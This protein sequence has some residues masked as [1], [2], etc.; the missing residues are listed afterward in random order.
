MSENSDKACTAIIL[1]AGRGTRMQSALPKVLHPVCGR[2]M[3]HWIIEATRPLCTRIVVVLGHAREQIQAT[4]P[5]DIQIAIQD[6]PQGTGDAVRVASSK[7]D[8][9]GIVLV[10]PG[11]APLIRQTTLAALIRGHKKALCSVLTAQIAPDQAPTSGYG[12]IVRD[13]TGMPVAIVEKASATAEQLEITEVNTGI[14]AFDAK[15]LFETVLPQLKA[16]PPKNEYYLTDAIQQAAEAG[17]LQAIEHT[18]LTEVTGVNDRIA[19][20]EL[21]SAARAEINREWMA[22][23]VHFVDPA[24]TYIGADVQL[25]PDVSL[26]PGVVLKGHTHIGKGAQIGAYA[27]IEDCTIAENVLVHSHSV[28]QGATLETGA[29]AGP[30]ARLREGTYL[31]P[32][33]KVGNFVEIKKTHL[34]EGAKAGHL[35]YLGDAKIGA[36]VNIGAGTIT[37]NYDGHAKHQTD[38]GDCAFIGSNTALVAPISVGAGALVAAGSTLT[39]DVPDKALA[40]ARS[41]QSIIEDAATRIHAKN[42][43]KAAERLK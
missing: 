42:A 23:G 7:V 14:Y 12:R 41:G 25:A 6:P 8:F 34:G 9:S 13:A 37:C 27:V 28:C 32:K 33:A 17:R 2:P 16:H 38:I 30:F 29:S 39:Q 21:E 24:C 19:L 11:D 22:K 31:G 36:G 26:G 1:A 10:L 20:A 15:W 18:N 43:E 3:L 4:L 35:S 5:P 40:V